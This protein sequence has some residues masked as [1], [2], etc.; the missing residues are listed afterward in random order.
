MQ[1]G[2]AVSD[3][4]RKSFDWLTILFFV[5]AIAVPLIALAAGWDLRDG[6]EDEKRAPASFPVWSWTPAELATYPKRFDA[7]LRDHFGFRRLLIRGHSVL[8]YYVLHTA[9]SPKVVIGKDGWLYYD[10]VHARDGDPIT[11][12][13]GIRAQTPYQL[14]GWRWAFQDISD[15]LQEQ[16]MRF[17]VVLIPAKEMIYP[18]YLP[19]HLAPVGPSASTQVVTYLGRHGRFEMLD[20]TPILRGARRGE[21]LYAKTD[22]HWN[23]YGAYV[24]YRAIIERLR[25]W[26]PG[27]QPWPPS[28]FRVLRARDR[29]GDLAQMM[30][31]RAVMTE[32]T[33]VVDALRP[34]RATSKTFGD[35][36]LPGVVA[37]IDDAS[38]PRA[39]IFRDSFADALIPHLSEHFRRALYTWSRQGLDL[40]PIVTERP[41]L[42][43]HIVADRALGR[44]FRYPTVMQVQANARRFDGSSDVLATIDGTVD[45]HGV[46]A[47]RGC[48]IER[49]GGDLLVVATAT[50]AQI[51]LPA[52]SR[53]DTVLPI[54]RVDVT[55]SG[56]TDLVI[57]WDNPRRERT[58]PSVRYEVSGPLDRGRT[59]LTLPLVDPEMTGPLR[60]QFAH[61]GKYLLH[62]IEVRGISRY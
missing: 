19:D 60:L 41:D 3:Q 49:Y 4:I 59:R 6:E 31:L 20:L 33:P 32:E 17:L 53:A 43:L 34:R 61:K 45:F 14:E 22:T 39:V 27:L 42:V 37:E 16:G 30:D 62:R 1:T 57:Q 23:S 9:P 5:V 36:D 29:A 44:R 7:W 48:S 54:M 58:P 56:R 25:A 15:W 55:A 24:G 18:E 8:S 11:E 50:Q 10:G 35:K 2:N 38:L 12:Y 26:Y 21:L 40:S 46:R 13:R 28:D 52:V 47:L 51:E